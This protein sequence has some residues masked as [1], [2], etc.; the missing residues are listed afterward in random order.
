[1][2]A[3]VCFRCKSNARIRK[4]QQESVFTRRRLVLRFTLTELSIFMKSRSRITLLTSCN[5]NLLIVG[6]TGPALSPV[7]G[8]CQF[9]HKSSDQEFFWEQDPQPSSCPGAQDM[10]CKNGGCEFDSKLRRTLTVR[11]SRDGL[12]YGRLWSEVELPKLLANIE[13]NNAAVPSQGQQS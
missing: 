13:K 3:V 2:K 10:S 8:G 7:S 4:H 11:L 12:R 9:P 5:V 1:M 6:L